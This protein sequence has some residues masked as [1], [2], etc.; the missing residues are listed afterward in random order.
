VSLVGV[1]FAAKT[2]DLRWLFVALPFALLLLAV[3][4]L[5]PTGYRLAADGV[6]VERRAGPKVIRYA[7]IRGV[8]REARPLA[9]LSVTASKGVFGRFGRFWN[10]TLGFYRLYVTDAERVVWLRTTEGWIGLSPEPADAFVTALRSR[11][12]IAGP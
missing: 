12:G 2:G 1:L 5:A 11:I 3:A 8:D 10:S 6:H 7:V 9:G 4:R